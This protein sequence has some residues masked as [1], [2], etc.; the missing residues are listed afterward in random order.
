MG[1][2]LVYFSY[3]ID[4]V[5]GML[6][7]EMLK[8]YGWLED[9]K[10]ELLRGGVDI[11]FDPGDAFRVRLGSD[12]GP[13]IREVNQLALQKADAMLAMLPL[14]LPSVGV[15][16]EIDIAV[17]AGKAVAIL[18]DVTVWMLQFGPDADYQ[19]FELTEEG[20]AQAVNW[21]LSHEQPGEDEVYDPLPFVVLDKEAGIDLT[22]QRKYKDDAGWDLVT[23][24]KTVLDPGETADV[25]CGIAVQLPSWAYGR[26]TGRSS[27]MRERSLLVGEGIIDTGYRGEL[28]VQATNMGGYTT[29]VEVGERIGQ[30]ILHANDSAAVRPVRVRDLVASERGINGFGSTGR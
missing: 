28:F 30:L 5:S 15:P 23:S 1:P 17:G 27:T 24:K 18:T 3:P 13:E 29:A 22:P 19:T 10:K 11:T 2:R 8:L 20:F 14:S 7:D 21:L 9:A 12:A 26:I 4:Q 6:T 16:M 25:P